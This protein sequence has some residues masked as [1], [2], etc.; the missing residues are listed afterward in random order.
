MHKADLSNS[1]TAPILKFPTSR[2]RA[3]P[4]PGYHCLS[5]LPEGVVR[6]RG[7][8]TVTRPTLP[9]TATSVILA[10]F[11][12][13]LKPAKQERLFRR[14]I[15]AMHDAQGENPVAHLAARDALNIF[16]DLTGPKR[17][18]PKEVS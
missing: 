7:P 18:E 16:M 2:K 13:D 14:L 12:A 3:Y 1:T 9:K 15:A 17:L 8:V 4:Q 6:L 10:A 11:L 5:S